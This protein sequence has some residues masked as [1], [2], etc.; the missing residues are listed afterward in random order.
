MEL[1]VRIVVVTV[2]LLVSALEILMLARAVLSW[3][4]FLDDDSPV[5][6]FLYAATEPV[7]LPIRALLERSETIANLPIDLSF[8]VAYFVLIFIGF[9]L[10]SVYF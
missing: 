10:P 2:R 7:I 6:R 1:F 8:F 9:M 5:Q 4:P 3:L